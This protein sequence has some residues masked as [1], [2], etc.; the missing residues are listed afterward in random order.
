MTRVELT[1]LDVN[2][3]VAALEERLAWLERDLELLRTDE[4]SASRTF[5]MECVLDA[6]LH[7]NRVRL[8]ILRGVEEP[9]PP[10]DMTYRRMTEEP[11][12]VLRAQWGDR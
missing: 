1:E 2:A 10:A 11:E 12:L 9:E 5:A 4:E 6:I 3:I 8:T 7:T